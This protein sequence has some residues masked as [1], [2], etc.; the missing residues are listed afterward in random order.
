MKFLLCLFRIL[1][2]PHSSLL[3]TLLGT[4]ESAIVA[5][6]Q[7]SPKTIADTITIHDHA[8]A[9]ISADA[10]TIAM[11]KQ[12]CALASGSHERIQ[13]IFRALDEICFELGRNFATYTIP[14]Q[15]DK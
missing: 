9:D 4:S 3:H 7:S 15:K 8:V 6:C 2:N 13:E 14:V 10:I 5:A 1:H 12:D 11:D